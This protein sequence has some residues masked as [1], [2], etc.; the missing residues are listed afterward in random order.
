MYRLRKRGGDV[1][2][3][4]EDRVRALVALCAPSANIL[5]NIIKFNHSP[6]DQPS[7]T[8]LLIKHASQYLC[9]SPKWDC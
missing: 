8:T 4:N 2:Q 9:T 7:I 1:R 3:E 5:V 6:N